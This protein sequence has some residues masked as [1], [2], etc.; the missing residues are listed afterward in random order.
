MIDVCRWIAQNPVI[1]PIAEMVAP[2]SMKM[3]VYH[4]ESAADSRKRN[5][6]AKKKAVEKRM[7]RL[8]SALMDAWLNPAWA[9]L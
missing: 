9:I 4:W 2:A 3:S 5:I 1:R 8:R 6:P 7:P